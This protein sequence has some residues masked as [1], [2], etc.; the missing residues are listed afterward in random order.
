MNSNITELMQANLN[1]SNHSSP[2]IATSDSGGSDVVGGLIAISALNAA[3]STAAGVNLAP[4]TQANVGS[5][6]DAILDA[7]VF[8]DLL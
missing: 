6:I 8:A 5:D 3:T 4:V 2:A 1:H 7:D